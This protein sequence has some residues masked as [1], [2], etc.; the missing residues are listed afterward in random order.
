MGYSFSPKP[1]CPLAQGSVHP[2]V[3]YGL[4][5]LTQ[6]HLSVSPRVRSSDGPLACQ[7]DA[8]LSD[9]VNVNVNGE[10]IY[11]ILVAKLSQW[12]HV[13]IYRCQHWFFDN[14]VH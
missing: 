7:S 2:M 14:I 9:N 12:V 4:Q 3:Q 5:F 6:A 8:L 13:E 10:F 1:I 11:C